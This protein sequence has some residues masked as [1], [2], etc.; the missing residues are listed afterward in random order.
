MAFAV[1]IGASPPMVFKDIAAVA[2]T[3]G[4]AATV[5]TPTAGKRFRLMGWRLSSSA[6]AALIFRYG[7]TPTTMFRTPLLAAAGVDVC[8]VA[9]NG[10]A[11]GA[12][13]EALKIDVS[14]NATVS[15]VVYGFEESV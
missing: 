13:G 14:A 15:G 6:A 2:V 5:W 3:A 10:F 1:D 9:C 4:T 11:P 8:E 7:A 12:A